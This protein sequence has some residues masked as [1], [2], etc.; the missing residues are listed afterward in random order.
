M[1]AKLQ[2]VAPTVAVLATVF[3]AGYLYSRAQTSHEYRI[4]SLE[5]Q[6]AGIELVEAL[7]R[8]V[9]ALEEAVAERENDSPKPPPAP[10]AESFA[11][12]NRVRCPGGG[13]WL[14]RERN[15]RTGSVTYTA[16]D[17]AWVAE[18]H[19]R[20]LADNSGSLGELRFEDWL[21]GDQN[22]PQ[23]V[24][25]EISCNPPDFPGAAGGWMEVEL[26]GTLGRNTQ[27][28]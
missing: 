27:A 18:A 5:E 12:R 28:R 10:E 21:D 17:G 24:W 13:D 26:Y 2:S 16:P 9:E 7:W 8:R 19:T 25:V 14:S 23:R 6:A 22:R 1:L 20:I 15:R 3:S 4:K 11:K